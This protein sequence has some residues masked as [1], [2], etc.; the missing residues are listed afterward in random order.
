[1]T[2]SKSHSMDGALSET[3]IRRD[4]QDEASDRCITAGTEPQRSDR[5][6]S[7]RSDAYSDVRRRDWQDGASDRYVAGFE[8]QRSDHGMV[9]GSGADSDIRRKDESCT[10]L[11][12]EVPSTLLD[13]LKKRH[14]YD[15][16]QQIDR[17]WLEEANRDNTEGFKKLYK[18]YKYMYDKLT[19][20]T[21]EEW[22]QMDVELLWRTCERL[23]EVKPEIWR[24]SSS[25]E[26]DD[27]ST[28]EVH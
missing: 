17:R 6:I 14:I 3:A 20:L 25:V 5:G 1:M 10:I 9:V 15:L 26:G 8:P 13:F 11:P 19:S 2:P 22:D 7:G 18:R 23:M 21:Q 12:D 16:L 28:T 4:W 27:T 24:M